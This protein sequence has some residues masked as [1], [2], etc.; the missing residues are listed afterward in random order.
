MAADVSHQVQL[1]KNCTCTAAIYM[2]LFY[3]FACRLILQG[4]MVQLWS[5]S[6]IQEPKAISSLLVCA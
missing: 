2:P 1:L 5:M 6:L 4:G 3:Y